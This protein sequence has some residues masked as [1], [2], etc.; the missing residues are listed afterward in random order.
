MRRPSGVPSWRCACSRSPERDPQFVKAAPLHAELLEA[1]RARRGR[2]RTALRSRAVAGLQ[3]GARLG[4]PDVRL[5]VGSGSHA[6]QTAAMLVGVERAVLDRR[7]DAML[8]YGD[9]NSTLAGAL[10][11][12]K[13]GVPLATSRPGCARSTCACPRRS[14]ASLTDRLSRLLFCPSDTR[15]RTSRRRHPRGVE[16]VGDVMV[17]LARVFGPV[18]QRTLALSRSARRWSRAPT[19]SRPSTARRTRSS[20][21][22]AGW[23]R[24]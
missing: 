15:S 7:P 9:T 21:R 3:R 10:A 13:L 18:G 5:E 1:R 8:V 24:A 16:L 22:S 14:T 17:D 23:S 12:A 6:E 4:E 2:H 20:R 19:R 11:A